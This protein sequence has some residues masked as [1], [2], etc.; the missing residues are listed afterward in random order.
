[1]RHFQT[2]IDW[3]ERIVWKSCYVIADAKDNS[4]T[5]SKGLFGRARISKMDKVKV[6]C[7][8]IPESSEYAFTFNPELEQETQLADIMYN[9]KYKCVGFESLVPTV[10]RIFY[11]YGLPPEI[12]VKLSIVGRKN[13]GIRYYVICKPKRYEAYRSCGEVTRRED[14]T[15]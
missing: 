10:N 3:F 1:M 7:F 13:N 5:F 2:I 15:S 14:K 9:D 12:K 8:L 11:D 4:I 6:L